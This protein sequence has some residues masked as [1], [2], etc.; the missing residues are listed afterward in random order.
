MVS[1]VTLLSIPLG[2]S[3]AAFLLSSRTLLIF[4]RISLPLRLI[5]GT[6]CFA[7]RRMTSTGFQGA[8]QTLTKD[9]W[10]DTIAACEECQ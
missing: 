4:L 9:M 7:D 3:V 1:S 2:L 6:C 10:F 5:S 8:E